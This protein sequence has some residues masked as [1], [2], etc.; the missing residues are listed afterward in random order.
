M[1]WFNIR[2]GI[3][4]LGGEYTYT[5]YEIKMLKIFVTR[6]FG[7]SQVV[8]VAGATNGDIPITNLYNGHASYANFTIDA[9]NTFATMRM[10]EFY[11]SDFASIF[12]KQNFGGNWFHEHYFRPYFSLVTNAGVGK[13]ANVNHQGPNTL[14][15]FNKGYYESGAQINN[16]LIT[17]NLINLGFGTFYRYGPYAFDNI[18][19]NFSYRLTINFILKK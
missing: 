1:I 5:K 3:P 12:L 16:L 17:D 13:L 6:L 9:E 7:Q 10:D 19:H 18:S 2:R 14:A 4:L 8:V 11:V 15:A